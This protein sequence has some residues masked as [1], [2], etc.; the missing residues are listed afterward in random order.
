MEDRARELVAKMEKDRGFS[1][2]WRI[3]LAERDPEFM[4]GIHK[5]NMHALFR[6]D[7]LPRKYVE[8][9]QI[10][11]NVLTFHEPGFRAHL[12]NALEEGLTEAEVIQ[13]LEICTLSGI[14]YTSKML[15]ALVEEVQKHKE[16]RGARPPV[17]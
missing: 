5:L 17:K 10:I 12:R 11:T 2:P 14:H 8:L 1:M 13:A 4:E 6:E 16:G 7:G 9:V 3:M 15:P